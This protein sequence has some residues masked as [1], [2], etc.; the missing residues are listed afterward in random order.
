MDKYF[1][2]INAPSISVSKYYTHDRV[3]KLDWKQLPGLEAIESPSQVIDKEI[4]LKDVDEKFGIENA[5]L[6]KWPSHISYLWHNDSDR[7]STINMQLFD[8][9]HSHTI[10]GDKKSDWHMDIEELIYEPGYFYLFN[11]QEPHEMINLGEERYLFTIR[12]S[13]NP[14]YEQILNWSIEK[15]WV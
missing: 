15:G 4:F 10:F 1:K 3:S 14:T 5:G 11:T 6:L 9:V 8:N 12:M 2:K 13:S 7:N